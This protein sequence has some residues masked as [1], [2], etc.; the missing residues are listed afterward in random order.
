MNN[1]EQWK[2]NG[3]C[4]KCR[5]KKYCGTK[6]SAFNATTKKQII[7]AFYNTKA[8]KILKTVE[9]VTGENEFFKKEMLPEIF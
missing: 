9:S 1:N 8:G 4:S 5:R 3:D 7:D 2:L 6:C